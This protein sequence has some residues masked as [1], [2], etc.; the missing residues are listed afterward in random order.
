MSPAPSQILNSY[1]MSSHEFSH[2]AEIIIL[3]V[4][5][6]YSKTRKLL[7]PS[8]LTKLQRCCDFYLSIFSIFSNTRRKLIISI[9]RGREKGHICKMGSLNFRKDLEVD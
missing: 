1:K 9:H 6:G 3:P 8:A 7:S 4:M 2:K 5:K